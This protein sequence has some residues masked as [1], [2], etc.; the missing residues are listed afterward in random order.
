[1]WCLSLNQYTFLPVS[2][3]SLGI[4]SLDWAE[5]EKNLKGYF[6]HTL[7]APCSTSYTHIIPVSKSPQPIFRCWLL[8][9]T[10]FRTVAYSTRNIQI[11]L[12][13]NLKRLDKFLVL[14]YGFLSEVQQMWRSW[15]CCRSDLSVLIS[16][17]TRSFF[18]WT[19]VVELE[20]FLFYT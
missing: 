12:A 3:S 6:I 4:S 1:M 7:N 13:A 18:L 15:P 19:G 10:I 14:F 20:L 16:F 8:D 2:R 11:S 9:H 5:L 17:Q